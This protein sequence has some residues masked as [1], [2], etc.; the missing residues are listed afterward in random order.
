MEKFFSAKVRIFGFELTWGDA[1][2]F[3]AAFVIG[4]GNILIARS[5]TLIS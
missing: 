3:W 5:S 2:L 4:Y 1:A